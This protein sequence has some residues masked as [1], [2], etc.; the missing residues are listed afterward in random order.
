M[1][2]RLTRHPHYALG[3]RGGGEHDTAAFL[4]HAPLGLR[5]ASDL[6]RRIGLTSSR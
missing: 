1:I 6:L 2:D 4:P 3:E 5:A